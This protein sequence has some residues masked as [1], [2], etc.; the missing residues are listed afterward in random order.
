MLLFCGYRKPSDLPPPVGGWPIHYRRSAML[1][2]NT[3]HAVDGLHVFILLFK[4][5]WTS[6]LGCM[7]LLGYVGL[8]FSSALCVPCL[9]LWFCFSLCERIF[10]FCLR[11][12]ALARATKRTKL[13]SKPSIALKNPA[14]LERLANFFFWV[15]VCWCCSFYCFILSV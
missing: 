6:L 1:S 3:P 13:K 9:D 4:L 12:F 14:A 8:C 7:R 5:W 11:N 10:D 2:V 15:R